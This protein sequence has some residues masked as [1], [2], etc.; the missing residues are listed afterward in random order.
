[1]KYSTK[2]SC[3]LSFLLS[4]SIFN[5]AHYK[6]KDAVKKICKD[7]WR[8]KRFHYRGALIFLYGEPPPIS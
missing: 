5:F 6:T 7:A 1:M 4:L 3:I 8:R 2:N